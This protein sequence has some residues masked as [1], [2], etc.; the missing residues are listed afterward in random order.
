MRALIEVVDTPEWGLDFDWPEVERE[1]GMALP[2][3]YRALCEHFG[4]GTFMGEIVF[5][6]PEDDDPD[7]GLLPFAR[8][9]AEIQREFREEGGHPIFPEP[10]GAFAW[11]RTANAL[12]L[13]WVTEGDPAD[14]RI[15]VIKGRGAFGPNDYYLYSGGI[16]QF[17]LDVLTA[18]IT[19][20]PYLDMRE[21]G[22]PAKPTFE[23]E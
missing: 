16:A 12:Q 15:A 7:L 10:G 11:G 22:D 4:A 18:R 9:V 13:C 5:T 20:L 19:D 21:F 2:P 17:L 14:W 3:D 23:P 8:D 6:A 1:L